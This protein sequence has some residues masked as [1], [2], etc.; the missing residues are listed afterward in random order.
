AQTLTFTITGGDDAAKFSVTTGGVLTFNAAPNYESPTDRGDDNTYEVQARADDGSRGTTTQSISVT[1]TPVNDNNPAFTSSASQSVAENPP[2]VTTFPYTALF[3]SAQT[4]TFTITGGDDAA[5]FSVTTGGVL[6][7]NAAPNYESPTDVGGNRSYEVQTTVT[8][9]SRSTTTQSISVTATPVTTITP[10]FTSSA[11][12]SVAETTTAI[13]TVSLPDALPISQTL[14]FT[15]TGGD[16]AAKF[17]I[18]G[19]GVL[20]F[21]AAPDYESPTDVG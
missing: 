12:Q 14:T 19:G 16:D 8:V 17:S 11:S 13:S 15:I 10:A 4:L 1:V 3:R 6:T 7:F 5:K 20:T 18:T 2:A 9:G 21:N